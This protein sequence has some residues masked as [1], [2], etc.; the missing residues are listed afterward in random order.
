MIIIPKK[1]I[2]VKLKPFPYN[3]GNK[4]DSNSI[5]RVLVFFV[6]MGN[7]DISMVSIAR[8]NPKEADAKI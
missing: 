5:E 6:F 2:M 4:I 7:D 3:R 1:H 8:S